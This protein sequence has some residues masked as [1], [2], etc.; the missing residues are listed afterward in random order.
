MDL[1]PACRGTPE[2]L[3]R[4][5]PGGSAAIR[6]FRER[7]MTCVDAE[8][9]IWLMGETGVGKARAG[10][11]LHRLG[12]RAQKPFVVLDVTL[13]LE[14]QIAAAADGTVLVAGVEACHASRQS[15]LQAW[16]ACWSRQTGPRPSIVLT[17]SDREALTRHAMGAGGA[18]SGRNHNGR[19][20]I[21]LAVPSLSERREDFGSLCC[22]LLA[23]E[24]DEGTP[25]ATVTSDGARYLASLGWPRNIDDLR[26]CLRRA[27]HRCGGVPLDRE[28]LAA[29]RREDV[30]IP[31][32]QR[33]AEVL[34][35]YLDCALEDGG[36]VAP[37]LHE[38]LIEEIERPLFIRVLRS[39]DGNQLRAAALLGMNRNTLRKRLQKLGVGTPRRGSR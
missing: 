24:A 21:R 4:D 30:L 5:L 3:A 1:Q 15:A 8:G 28:I 34:G 38:R 19:N 22:H 32:A 27:S 29:A 7:L 26:A 13:D 9:P 6:N 14:G 20:D 23:E 2:A 18:I 25:V 17:V 16:L 11:L 36:V 39:T 37:D 10:W 31:M 12:C 35:S 33:L